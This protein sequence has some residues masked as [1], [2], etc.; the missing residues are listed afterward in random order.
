VN[1]KTVSELKVKIFLIADKAGMLEMYAKPFIQG[2]TTNPT[3]MRK[4][5]ISNYIEFAQDILRAM[6]D[7]PISFEV[8]PT[9]FR[10][11]SAGEKSCRLG[12]ERL[13]EDSRYQYPRR[14]Q[15]RS[16]RA[17]ISQQCSGERPAIMTLEQVREVAAA[18][19]V[20]LHPAFSVFAGRIADTGQDPLPV[21]VE[22]LALLKASPK[23]ELIWAS[24]ANCS[25]FFQADEIGCHIIT[26]TNDILKKL[27]GAGKDLGRFLWK[28]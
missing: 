6:P 7:R 3:L 25:T 17:A 1:L 2:F 19:R 11:W 12:K 22:S 14:G 20:E 10:R 9:N 23:A 8:F 24:P 4:A 18:L 21:M 16:G 27:D 5:G 15:L 26:V 28:P 13:R